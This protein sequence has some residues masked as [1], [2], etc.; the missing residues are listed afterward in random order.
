MIDLKIGGG[1]GNQLFQYAAARS[2]ALKKGTGLNIDTSFYD[3]FDQDTPRLYLLELFNVAVASYEPADSGYFRTVK[4]NKFFRQLS[5]Y[6]RL[7]FNRYYFEAG[8]AFYSKFNQLP[9]GVWLSGYFESDQ[10]FKDYADIIRREITLKE[11]FPV[12][13]VITSS[14]SVFVHVR[15]GDYLLTQYKNFH[16]LCPLDYY[17]RAIAL[18]REQVANPKFFIFSDD[19]VWTKANL[20]VAD[21]VYVSGTGLKDYQELITMSRCQH[22]IIADSTFSWW[23]AW[24]IKNPNKVV[25]A[26]QRWFVSDKDN[27]PELTPPEWI[28]L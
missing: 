12:D 27:R 6:K 24:L 26:P 25:I 28:R 2:L 21:A 23:G 19:I 16:S 5:F 3:H 18:M 11:D 9:D 17:K 13:P 22:A 15:R 14:E 20:D 8:M 4:L 10:Y 1:L 7:Y